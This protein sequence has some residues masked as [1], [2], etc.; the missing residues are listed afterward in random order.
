MTGFM[1]GT[2]QRFLYRHFRGPDNAGQGQNPHFCRPRPLQGPAGG[3]G[4]PSGGH[5]IVHQQNI[6]PGHPG[7]FWNHEG[8]QHMAPPITIRNGIKGTA[9]R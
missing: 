8:A 9:P 7:A 4:G 3:F 1:F 5:D 6:A 2:L